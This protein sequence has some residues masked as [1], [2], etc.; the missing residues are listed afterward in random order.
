MRSAVAII[1][2]F[3]CGFIVVSIIQAI[4][5]AIYA[6]PA[7]FDYNDPTALEEYVATLPVTAFI[8]VLVSHALGAFVAAFVCSAIVR[9]SWF[10]ASLFFGVFFT[11]AG[12]MN[13]VLIPHP[14][15]F[16]VLDLV[17]Y[18]PAAL[19]GGKLAGRTV[20]RPAE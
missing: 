17:A 20:A 4:S 7:G 11:A 6:P 19:L 10:A 18:I 3:I 13:L 1:A 8:L 2:G 15:W 5:S 9:R 14:I 16:A 12:I